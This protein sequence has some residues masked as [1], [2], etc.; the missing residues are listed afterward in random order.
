MP[1]T[2]IWVRWNDTRHCM[3]SCSPVKETE[4]RSLIG[5]FTM[6]PPAGVYSSHTVLTVTYRPS[7]ETGRYVVC[8]NG[9]EIPETSKIYKQA[10]KKIKCTKN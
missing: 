6:K 4:M 1:F 7:T 5:S 9:K 3:G 10:L 2:G 8:V